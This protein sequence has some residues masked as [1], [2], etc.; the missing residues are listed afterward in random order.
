MSSMQPLFE[1]TLDATGE[2]QSDSLVVTAPR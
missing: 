2:L 1:A